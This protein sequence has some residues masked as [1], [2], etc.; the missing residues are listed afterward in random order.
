[1]KVSV[2]V[3][4]YKDFEALDL[5]V[6]AL[7]KQ[8]YSNIELVVA[9]DNNAAEMKAY[10]EAIEGLE[11]KHTVQEDIGIRKA[12]S[13]NN[14]IL[15]ST[16]DYLIFI[17]GDCIP[18]TTFVEGHVKLSA[19]DRVLSGRRVNLGPRYSTMLR[20]GRL[21]AQA[22]E[23]SFFWRY[24]LIASD[25]VEGHSEA[26]FR[27]NPDGWFF[28][29]FRKNASTSLLGCNFSLYKEQM[30]AING[31][32]EG[33]GATSYSDDTDLQWRFAAKGLELRSCKNVANQFHLYHER[34]RAKESI[35]T[36]EITERFLT[37]KAAGRYICETGLNSHETPVQS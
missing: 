19:P 8:T 21:S 36:P 5:I 15:A 23:S 14:G 24:P 11:V 6:N 18:Y 7:K 22:L 25:A 17:D 28:R 27:L 29:T 12:R 2:I 31:F 32:D 37:N 33:Y 4:V 16:G 3:A 1:M 26:G 9:E 10:V 13:Q 30:T 35:P 34:V 20:S